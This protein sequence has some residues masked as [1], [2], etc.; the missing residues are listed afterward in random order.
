MAITQMFDKGVPFKTYT[1]EELVS[2]SWGNL[3]ND[4][5]W[6][7]RTLSCYRIPG[8][9]GKLSSG[10]DI[11]LGGEITLSDEHAAIYGIWTMD[12]SPDPVKVWLIG[13]SGDVSVSISAFN[14]MRPYGYI[15]TNHGLTETSCFSSK[16]N[17]GY[18]EMFI[19]EQP[20]I[21]HLLG[22]SNNSGNFVDKNAGI[23][24]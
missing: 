4:F 18:N 24:V 17:T 19:H 21:Q 3:S 8:E 12:M 13:D 7:G 20:E 14:F 5:K 1:R 23:V 6:N 16:S 11:P 9:D 15:E 22:N 10:T 2:S